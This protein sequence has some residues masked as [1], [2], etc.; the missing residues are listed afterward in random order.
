MTA[1]RVLIERA[2]VGA[3]CKDGSVLQLVESSIHNPTFAGVAAYIKK[4][5]YGPAVIRAENLSYVG[6]APKAKAQTG[7]SVTI[8]G[9]EIPT[10]DIDV[11]ALYET[12]MSKDGGR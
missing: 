11:E 2:L 5:E 8:D 7:S 3:V 12:V 9:A 4:P 10:E 6:N 1:R